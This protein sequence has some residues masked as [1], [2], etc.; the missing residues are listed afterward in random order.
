MVD[1]H[2]HVLP[3]V[4]DGPKD[5]NVAEEMCHIAAQDGITHIVA[6]PHSNDEFAYDRGALRA[7]L[8]RLQTVCGEWPMLTLGCDF[9][10]SYENVSAALGDPNRFSIGNTQY[11]LVEFSDFALSLPM[12]EALAR[13]VHAG[14]VPIVTHPERNLLMQQNHELILKLLDLGCLVQVT[15]SSLTGRW[16]DAAR[17][18]ALWLLKNDAVHVLATDAHD[19]VHRPPI[20]SAGRDA[21]AKLCG[22]DVARALVDDNPR[23]IVSG[24]MVPYV[25]NV[26]KGARREARSL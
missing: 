1:I 9:H 23:A 22:Q 15:A 26:K 11:L 5:W 20:L 21:A 2:C 24:E 10:F 19:P 4:D 6:T 12:R 7:K 17:A 16:G 14:L 13:L 8:T 25:P 3:N 18:T